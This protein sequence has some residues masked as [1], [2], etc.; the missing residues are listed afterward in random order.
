MSTPRSKR[1]R[2]KKLDG[3]AT[4]RAYVERMQSLDRETMSDLEGAWLS[5]FDLYG[6]LSWEDAKETVPDRMIC[7]ATL[8]MHVARQNG[9]RVLGCCSERKT[10]GRYICSELGGE[11]RSMCKVVYVGQYNYFSDHMSHP[12]FS[13]K[14]CDKRYDDD[15][16]ED[17]T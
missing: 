14:R 10:R 3:E 9:V 12:I 16:E 15:D 13:V 17:D 5:T 1:R 8:L 6:S 2:A 7:N 4:L 11:P